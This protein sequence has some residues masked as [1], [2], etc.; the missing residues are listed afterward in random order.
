MFEQPEEG[1]LIYTGKPLRVFFCGREEEC[2]PYFC[3]MED[4]FDVVFMGTGN[5]FI[6]IFFTQR[7]ILS[8]RIVEVIR[9]VGEI[10][11]NLFPYVDSLSMG[12]ARDDVDKEIFREAMGVVI[13]DKIIKNIIENADQ[14]ELEELALEVSRGGIPWRPEFQKFGIEDSAKMDE[15]LRKENAILERLQV[16]LKSYCEFLKI[17]DEDLTSYLEAMAIVTAKTINGSDELIVAVSGIVGF[18]HY[19]SFSADSLMNIECVVFESINWLS[20]QKGL[21][22]EEARELITNAIKIMN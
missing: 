15:R 6:T 22:V 9:L 3:R 16:P 11:E 8:C 2:R 13:P 20:E 5:F 18:D 19:D 7:P 1:N 14:F 12:V 21:P 10:G 17:K 4:S